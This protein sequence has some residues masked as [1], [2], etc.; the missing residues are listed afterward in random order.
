[1]PPGTNNSGSSAGYFSDDLRQKRDP[2]TTGLNSYLE[3][4][5]PQARSHIRTSS[6]PA[7]SNALYSHNPDT[8]IVVGTVLFALP[9]LHH[10]KVSVS[11]AGITA[12]VALSPT[13]NMPLGPKSSEVIQAGSSV[14][15][16]W[17]T[18]APMPFII[19]T[20]PY[21][22]TD[23]KKGSASVLQTGGNSNV[24]KQS[25]YRQLPAQ[26]ALDGQIQNSGCGKPIDG[27]NFEHS[28]TTETSTSFLLDAYQIALSIDEGTGLFLNWFDNYCRLS[29]FQLDLQSYAEHVTQRYD[30]GENF[31]LRGGLI[32]PWESVGTYDAP[33]GGGSDFT[34]KYKAKDYQLDPSQPF[35]NID[36]PEDETDIV[37][38]YRYMEYGGYMGQGSTRMLM[39]PAPDHSGAKGRRHAKD[40][41]IDYGLWQENVALDGS[42]TM[43]SAKSVSI[44]KYSFIPIPKRIKVVEDQVSEADG[45]K[46]ANY[47]FS[48]Q[49]EPPGFSG[50]SP[51]IG[52]LQPVNSEKYKQLNKVAGVLDLLAFN[53]NWKSSHP[54]FYHK[55]DYNFPDESALLAKMTSAYYEPAYDDLSSQSYL[56]SPEAV[57]LKIDH[58]YEDVDYFQSSSHIT[59][60]DDGGIVISDGYGAQI[61][62]TGG[63]IRLEAPG[64]VMLM[65]GTRTVALCDEF[66]VR[67][68]S[69]IELSS[70]EKDI[71]LKA[72][73]N[74]QLL[75]GNS[76]EGGMLIENKATSSWQHRYENK[77]GEDV[78]DS[79]ITLLAKSSG[80]GVV[81]K[82]VYVRS[83]AG[84]S[85][86][87]LTLDSAQGE[88]NIVMYG[89]AVHIFESDGLT[90]WEGPVGSKPGSMKETHRFHGDG[91]MHSSPLYCQG[92]IVAVDGNIVAAKS[93]LARENI[94]CGQTLGHYGSIF[95]ADLSDSPTDV[96]GIIDDLTKKVGDAIDDRISQGKAVFD[97]GFTI[98]YSKDHLGHNKFISNTIGFSFNDKP[99]GNSYGYQSDKF[100]LLSPKWQS[101]ATGEKASWGKAW[102]EAKVLYQGAD[103]YPWPGKS[104]WTK[105][106]SLLTGP[107][108]KYIEGSGG[109]YH[110]SDRDG[111]FTTGEFETDKLTAE[112]P[113]GSYILIG[114][115]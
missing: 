73:N 14:L 17:P 38:I 52:D 65:P 83:G 84:G 100:K 40:S 39:L 104:N 72:E 23:S 75:S 18:S 25:A 70:S 94:M 68:K 35:G 2:Q 15:L 115:E 59:M 29:G 42:Y 8:H 97:S 64:D 57:S 54:F 87:Q 26:L 91:T 31:S 60:L 102:T 43:R 56:D 58:R 30:E 92:D 109:V 13:G 103:S 95:V 33:S 7:S 62:M 50:D 99:D 90:L 55:G 6:D 45:W 105:K 112:V 81:G 46:Q 63:Q 101:T 41:D 86:G 113:D 110:G 80:V 37:P 16:L 21:I 34:A 11:G 47:K 36:L 76:G 9:Y 74:M 69:N 27:T 98:L 79:G 3:G 32:Y 22:T 108:L 53:Y 5:N 48:G 10:Y 78:V 106:S 114:G 19:G 28:I 107:T 4:L 1:M 111:T 85:T 67:A 44:G 93:V 89:K 51:E 12:A 96:R 71:R 66:I 82:D 20:I 77:Y 61:T 88:S 49:F 24:L